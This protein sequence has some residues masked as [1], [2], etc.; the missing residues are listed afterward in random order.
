VPPDRW[1]KRGSVPPPLAP[2][3]DLGVAAA[4]AGRVIISAFLLF[5]GAKALEG[6]GGF[7]QGAIDAKVV[8]GE[9][10]PGFG[11]ASNL[12]EE[13]LCHLRGKQA[14]SVLGETR[15]VPGFLREGEAHEP[16]EEQV[17]L[18]VLAEAALRGDGV[19]NL[20]DLARKRHSG[21]MERRPRSA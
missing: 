4:G 18:E 15:R 10:L 8:P 1:S 20:K 19:E 3:I 12:L 6:G 2:E 17:V 16:A 13:H 11:L 9:E 21:G 5:P 14:V 7:D